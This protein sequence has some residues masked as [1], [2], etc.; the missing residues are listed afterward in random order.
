MIAYL[1][2][3]Y[4][5]ILA[6]TAPAGSQSTI[7][8][9]Y[10]SL[11]FIDDARERFLAALSGVSAESSGLVA[12]LTIGE[13]DMVSEDLAAA[14]KTLSLTHLVAVSGANLAIVMGLVYLVASVLGLARGPRLTIALSLMVLYVLL[15][16]PE[17]SVIRAAVMATFVAIGLWIGRGSAPIYGLS[18]AVIVLLSVDPALAIDFGFALSALATA[19]LLILAPLIYQRLSERLPNWLAAGV[20]ATVAAQLYTLPVLMMLQ[21]SIPIYSVIANLAVEPAVAPITIIGIATVLLAS[22]LPSLAGPA[23]YLASL[24][25]QWIVLVAFSLHELPFARISF[26]PG[27]F[28]ISVVTVLTLLLT[29][30]LFSNSAHIRSASAAA[31]IL[32][33]V[34]SAGWVVRDYTR[35]ATFAGEWQVISCDVG[36]GDAM[37]IRSEQVALIDTGNDPRALIS[38][39]DSA[40]VGS[41]DLLFLTHYDLDHVGA[42]TAIVDRVSGSVLVTGFQDDRPVVE[43]ITAAF[44]AER[45]FEAHAG[46]TG[47]LGGVTWSVLGPN[48]GAGEALDSNDA[49]IITLFDFGGYSVLALGDLGETGQKRLLGQQPS[50]LRQ[51]SAKPLILKV[52]HHGSADQSEEMFQA[53]SPSIAVFSVGKNTYGHPTKSAL[54]MAEQAGAVSLRTDEVGSIAFG[55][56]DGQLRFRVAGKLTT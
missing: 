41:I 42:A 22:F 39:L 8:L 12:G 40:G 46:L 31:S 47:D 1:A 7:K 21:P 45:I 44:G 55:L 26:L 17:S 5:V 50:L 2:G 24:P 30:R 6:A 54:G 49:S 10:P 38:C 14:M 13:R 16:G 37:L 25:A 32:V 9:S 4:W 20:A 23:S 3:I 18:I 27:I 33:M 56:E 34:L 28:G 43:A 51:I 19:G 29:L 48:P 35:Q 36:Q 15:V 53:L 11:G 52:A